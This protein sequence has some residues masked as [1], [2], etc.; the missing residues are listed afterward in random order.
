MAAQEAQHQRN[1]GGREPEPDRRMSGWTGV[2]YANVPVGRAFGPRRLV[3]N[4]GQVERFCEI[5]GWSG[6]RPDHVPAF[7]LNELGTLKQFLKLPPGVLH[8]RE[9]LALASPARIGEELEVCI[10]VA[11]KF[12]RNHKRFVVFAQ[13]IRSAGDDRLIMSI[14][15]TLYWPC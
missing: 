8:A 11:D 15:R 2:A 4:A 12:I 6:S 5:A 7:L 13:T 14:T 10:A 9:E 1:E 3:R